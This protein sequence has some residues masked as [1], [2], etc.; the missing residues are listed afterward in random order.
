MYYLRSNKLKNVLFMKNE[1]STLVTG[2]AGI[3]AVEVV[4]HLPLDN[5]GSAGGIIQILVQLVIGVVTLLGL[6][7]KKK[8]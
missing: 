2:G 4:P 6:F 3:S 8:V 1:I 7:K 5:I